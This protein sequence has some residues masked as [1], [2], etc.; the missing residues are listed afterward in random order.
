MLFRL[1][2]WDDDVGDTFTVGRP[3]KPIQT[4]SND[5][6]VEDDSTSEDNNDDDDDEFHNS[7]EEEEES[8]F[9]KYG[10][11]Q[12]DYDVED[13]IDL[14]HAGAAP[15]VPWVLSNMLPFARPPNMRGLLS[16]SDGG[17]DKSG[18][19]GEAGHHRRRGGKSSTS[20]S[21]HRNSLRRGE[22]NSVKPR[23]RKKLSEAR[24]VR[25]LTVN[26]TIF[27]ATLNHTS[28][29]VISLYSHNLVQQCVQKTPFQ[30]YHCH[31]HYNRMP[32][33][34]KY[35]R[36]NCWFLIR[37]AKNGLYLAATQ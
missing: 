14:N 12:D 8:I 28:P 34:S 13:D 22:E 18:G 2:Q 35:N 4:T 16:L 31:P 37:I 32:N 5:L 23:R 36:T 11:G 10:G 9:A 29:Q 6:E 25:L 19:D 3:S 15:S 24:H 1:W 21:H 7:L 17:R 30:P 20:S 33:S 27:Y 26:E